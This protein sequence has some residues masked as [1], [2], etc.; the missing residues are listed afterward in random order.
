MIFPTPR[1]RGL[2]QTDDADLAET[3]ALVTNELNA[4]YAAQG[5]QWQPGQVLPSWYT[6]EMSPSSLPSVQASPLAQAN[7]AF[8]QGT[9]TPAQM[10][11][12]GYVGVP[13]NP[14]STSS[15]PAPTYTTPAPTPTSTPAAVAATTPT[16]TTPTPAPSTAP[17]LVTPTPAAAPTC[18]NGAATQDSNGNWTCPAAPST[19][20]DTTTWLLVGG[21]AILGLML[22]MKK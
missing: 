19:S 11:E 6:P 10:A 7:I 16:S 12:G 4:E 15:T 2:S 9:A 17:P 20:D 14:P 8:A 18:A 5:G 3:Q 21:A 13:E 1:L 22:F